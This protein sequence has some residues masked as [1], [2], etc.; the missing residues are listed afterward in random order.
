MDEP[1]PSQDSAAPTDHAASPLTRD[2]VTGAARAAIDAL[3]EGVPVVQVVRYRPGVWFW[4]LLPF[5]LVGMTVIAY[6]LG[7]AGGAARSPVERL[8]ALR[9]DVGRDRMIELRAE[10]T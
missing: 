6:L 3:G 4:W 10:L 5:V 2:R 7:S 9:D 8:D 1:I